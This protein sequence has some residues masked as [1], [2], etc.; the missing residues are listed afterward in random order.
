MSQTPK[1]KLREALIFRENGAPVKIA[2]AKITTAK[3][4]FEATGTK[5]EA[6]AT[7]L[8]GHF[9]GFVWVDTQPFPEGRE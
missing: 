7:F 8:F 1:L 2:A 9:V 3:G 5:G 4:C 6:I